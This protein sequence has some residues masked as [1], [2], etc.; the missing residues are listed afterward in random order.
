MGFGLRGA[1]P[2]LE[3]KIRSYVY[4]AEEKQANLCSLAE[5]KGHLLACIRISRGYPL[6]HGFDWG[7][8]MAL[9]GSKS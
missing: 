6:R 9:A 7:R 1:A 5:A 4:A 2:A 8:G 3:G